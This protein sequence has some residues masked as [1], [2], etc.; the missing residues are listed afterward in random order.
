MK[1]R[2]ANKQRGFTLIELMIVVVVISILAAVA[3][4]SY[5]SYVQRGDRAGAMAALLQYANWMQQQYT[6]N[7]SYQPGGAALTLP[8]MPASANPK[9]AFTISASSASTFT[10][11]AAPVKNDKC[12]TFLLDNTGT[13]TTK[14]GATPAA[15]TADCWAGR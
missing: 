2:N 5:R 4:P 12:G 9:Y 3:V 6:V 1:F 8:A 15:S 13:R 14:N 10:L 11:S 7:N